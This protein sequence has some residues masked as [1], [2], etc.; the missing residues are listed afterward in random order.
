MLYFINNIAIVYLH[1]FRLLLIEIKYFQIAS[2]LLDYISHV[3]LMFAVISGK[4]QHFCLK[5]I[6]KCV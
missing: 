5:Q 3:F 1:L 4:E 6:L 2:F